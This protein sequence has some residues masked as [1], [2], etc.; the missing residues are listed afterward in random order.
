MATPHA[1]DGAPILL[2]VDP[3]YVDF[4]RDHFAGI[5]AGLLDDLAHHT[6]QLRDAA[7]D[8]IAVERLARWLAELDSHRLIG[9]KAELQHVLV[10][11]L[12]VVDEYNE[13]ARVVEEHDAFA[14]LLAKLAS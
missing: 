1:N 12:R 2:A 13:Y 14:H 3:R 5:R 4:L 10:V 9:A 8:R 7:G 6:H 11:H